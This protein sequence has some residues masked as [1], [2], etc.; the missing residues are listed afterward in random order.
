[1]QSKQCKFMNEKLSVMLI[2]HLKVKETN[3]PAYRERETSDLRCCTRS[4]AAVV[5][6]ETKRKPIETLTH[7][8]LFSKPL[9]IIINTSRSIFF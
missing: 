3:S 4:A 9:I 1:M 8:L 5:D 7:I 2:F 6:D